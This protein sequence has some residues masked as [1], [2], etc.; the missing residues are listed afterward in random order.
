[1]KK[2]MLAVSVLLL[3]LSANVVN[4][5]KIALTDMKRTWGASVPSSYTIDTVV[6]TAPLYLY[7]KFLNGPREGLI[8]TA[9]A[10]EI[11][12]TTSGTLSL[13]VSQDG[14]TWSPYYNSKDS[15]YVLTLADNTS[16]QNYR[17][18]IAKS[19]DDYFRVKGVGGGTVNYSFF[20]KYRCWR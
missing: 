9:S 18:E 12:G 20:V 5:Q 17:W 16:T 11:S 1:M 7:S 13:E 19:N 8:I 2:V 14:T 6:S 15:V 4:G 3:I 10:I